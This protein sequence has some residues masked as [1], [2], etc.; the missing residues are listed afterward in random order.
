MKTVNQAIAQFGEE[1]SYEV[2]KDG[3]MVEAGYGFDL[4]EMLGVKVAKVEI[5]NFGDEDA[6]IIKLYVRK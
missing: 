1:W 2:Y 3:R 5:E 6:Q 4:S